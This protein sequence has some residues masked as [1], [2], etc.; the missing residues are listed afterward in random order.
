MFKLEL[1]LELLRLGFA[2]LD[3]RN[4]L[5]HEGLQDVIET[6]TVQKHGCPLCSQLLVLI[7]I[8]YLNLILLLLL[9]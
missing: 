6:V 8:D 4:L 9:F 5:A 7:L 1:R 2:C 3:C